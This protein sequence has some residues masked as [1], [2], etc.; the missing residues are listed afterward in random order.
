MKFCIIGTGDAG[1]V[2]AYQ[3]RLLDSKSH[4]DIFSLRQ[5]LGIPPCEMPLVLRGDIHNWEDLVRGFRGDEFFYKKR[6][7]CLHLNTKVTDIITSGKYILA[8]GEKHSYDKLILSIGA[9]TVIPP[10]NGLDGN[11][12]FTLSTDQ[13][14]GRILE[15]VISKNKTAAIIGGGF[16]AL[17]IADALKSRGYEKV[18]L[19]AR[20]GIMR[21]YLDE[22]MAK[23]L[24][25][26]LIDNGIELISPCNTK[27][28]KTRDGKKH[29]ILGDRELE[30]DF[31]F[32]GTGV[33]PNV[34]LA[35]E[36]G[37]ELGNTGALLVNQFLQT[38]DPDIYAAG[39]CMENWDIISGTKR[40]HQSATNAIRTGFI[41]GR[42]SLLGNKIAYNG[43]VMPFVTKIFGY[44]VGSV[45]F[46]EHEAAEKGFDTVSTNVKTHWLH[47]R[48]GGKPAI[49]K[50]VG[51]RDTKT[52]IGAQMISEEKVAGTVDK[53][54]MAIA[55][56]MKLIDLVQ[57]DSCYS[58]FVQEDQTG[59]PLQ[60]LSDLLS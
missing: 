41:A 57:I 14:D 12:E 46:T 9:K 13:A 16:L 11:N 39:D 28:I 29:L 30:V 50:L 42:N 43:T 17:E 51:D 59:I 54:A 38:S 58:P 47:K 56:K 40:R 32:F 5:E 36:T 4:I 22:D 48:F 26:V 10:L 23:R 60:R 8:R 6:N 24:K 49:Y 33:E 37:L 25:Q 7:I 21:A 1:A 19:L 52:L 18:Y 34:Q 35:R 55:N 27:Q 31:I 15:Q 20:H 44:H 45:G 3:L 53:F 2:A